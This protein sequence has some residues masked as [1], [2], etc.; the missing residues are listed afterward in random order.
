MTRYRNYH[1]LGHA[2]RIVSTPAFQSFVGFFI[3]F[4]SIPMFSVA[5]IV[6]WRR[7][8]EMGVFRTNSVKKQTKRNR[9][10]DSRQRDRNRCSPLTKQTL[11]FPLQLTAP[12]FEPVL[13]PRDIAPQHNLLKNT[14]VRPFVCDEPLCDEEK[15]RG[16]FKIKDRV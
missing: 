16:K 15:Q 10:R 4:F 6:K 1:C 8:S 11:E 7:R 5:G 3:Y 9:Y 13:V 14:K 12:S 2:R